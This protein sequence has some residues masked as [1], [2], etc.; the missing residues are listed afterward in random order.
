MQNACDIFDLFRD[1]DSVSIESRADFL[2]IVQDVDNEEDGAMA[3]SGL[4]LSLLEKE[5]NSSYFQWLLDAYLKY[6]QSLS[7]MVVER[8]I[9]GMILVMVRHS[10]A[11]RDNQELLESVQDV[12]T[13]VPELAF[14]AICNIARTSQIK[15]LEAFNHQMTKELMPLMDKVGSDEFFDVIRKYQE[16]LNHIAKLQ[17]DQNFL[18]FKTTYNVP[19]FTSRAANWFLP[20]SEK[21][22][23]NVVEEDREQLQDIL[24]IWPMCDSD[25][26]ALLSVSPMLRNSLREQLQVDMLHQVGEN[27]GM[28]LLITNGYVQQMYRY[29]RLS[30]FRL[31]AVDKCSP[32]DVVP[33]LRD[34]LVY[35]LLVVGD[36]AHNTIN[37]LLS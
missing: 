7:D 24:D 30:S 17:L 1:L 35:R 36:R 8:L 20:W 11:I 28:S 3:V 29:F 31:A 14:T 4:T 12:F 37:E 13:D 10:V 16:D 26:Y 2:A 21:Q 27:I 18:I 15:K 9:V 34:T 23:Q 5:W 6:A 19:F 33:H 22:L 32:F 25:K